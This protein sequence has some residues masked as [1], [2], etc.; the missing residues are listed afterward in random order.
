MRRAAGSVWGPL[1]MI[2]L[3]CDP[4]SGGLIQHS[5]PVGSRDH[6][7]YIQKHP[8]QSFRLLVVYPQKIPD[9]PLESG[10]GPE[11]KVPCRG[12]YS[13]C[14]PRITSSPSCWTPHRCTCGSG[15]FP[16]THAKGAPGDQ[17]RV[18]PK[19]LV[20][21]YLLFLLI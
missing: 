3:Y 4:V 15:G 19:S 1:W 14:R 13:P 7:V 8:W 6:L 5:Q 20:Y 21:L 17:G 11:C 18:E 9:T 12:P 10:R 2:C 16:T